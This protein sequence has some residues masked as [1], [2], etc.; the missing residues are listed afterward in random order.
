MDNEIINILKEELE[1]SAPKQ[2]VF[3][4]NGVCI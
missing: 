3:E 1:Q 4:K 2:I